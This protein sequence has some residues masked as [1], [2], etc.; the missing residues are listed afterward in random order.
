MPCCSCTR[1][2]LQQPFDWLEDVEQVKPPAP[3]EPVSM[4]RWNLYE[5]EP[6][7]TGSERLLT[8]E[9]ACSKNGKTRTLSIHSCLIQPLRFR[10]R[11]SHSNWLFP[12]LKAG[13][14]HD[15]RTSYAALRFRVRRKQSHAAIA[16]GG[17]E[18]A[19]ALRPPV[20]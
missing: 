19:S 9:A 7:G 10:M 4:L 14:M 20:Q 2:V 18:D 8:I 17:T 12:G 15:I 16:M 3:L 11:E 5:V 13:P 6:G 1:E